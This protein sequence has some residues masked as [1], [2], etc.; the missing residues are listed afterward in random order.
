MPNWIVELVLVTFLGLMAWF[1]KR[2]IAQ[3][4]TSNK[5]QEEQIDILKKDLQEYKLQA[6]EKYVSKDEFIR[7]TS[8][9]QRKLDQIYDE[10]IKLNAKH[11][12]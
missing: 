12:T 4:D 5:K 8:H 7:A 3:Q 9:T 11:Q 2:H 10:I 1:L 6:A